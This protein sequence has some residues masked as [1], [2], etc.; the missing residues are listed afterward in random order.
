MKLA[1]AIRILLP[2]LRL[3]PWSIPT[4]VIVGIV[5]SF[6]EGIGI[7]LFIPF[8]QNLDPEAYQTSSDNP[9]LATLN[10][11]LSFV[12]RDRRIF[13]LPLLIFASII[14]KHSLAYVNLA[15][16]ARL[17]N[18]IGHHL[19]SRIFRQLMTIN[20][21]YLEAQDSGKLLNTLSGETWRV[22]D[23]IRL[24]VMLFI[25][26]ST[27]FVFTLLLLLLSWRLTL[28]VAVMMS[29]IA[30]SVQFLTRQS[31]SLGRQ[32]VV[33]NGELSTRMCEG[34]AGMRT[35]RAFGR[36]DYE[37]NRFDR[38][39][40]TTSQVFMKV[41]LL[42]GL[43]TPLYEMLSGALVL[44]IL[45]AVLIRDPSALPT[46]LT[47]LFILYRLQ[48]QIQLLDSNRIKL[49]TLT[50]SIADVMLFLDPTDKPYTQSGYATFNGLQK[51]IN[52]EQVSFRYTPEDQPA[53]QDIALII[54]QG[55]TTAL[56]GPSGAGKSTL[57]NL[58]CRFYEP[59]QGKITID[60]R[61]LPEL[62][63][64]MWRSRIAIVS[65][66]IYIFSGTVRDNIAYGRL[67]A[68]EAEIIA[69]AQQANAHDFILQLPEGYDT[70]VGDRGMRLSGGQRQR[71][72]LA[73]AIVR[74]PDILI[75]DEATNALD[76]ISEHLIQEALD[77]FSRAPRSGSLQGRTV[78]V[79]AHR[80]STIEQADQIAV[81]QQGRI[82]EV[83]SL[84]QLLDNN[85][86]FAQL[87]YLQYR[88]ANE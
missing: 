21:S 79:I 14:L 15:L 42:S 16:F 46:L 27:V 34:L 35:I 47:F 40:Q 7:S 33:A 6:A 88:Q 69:A 59:S 31:T 4:I 72:A 10:S 87:H 82:V 24:L 45:V 23:A 53:L 38:A 58:I 18:Q 43:V 86:L 61:P 49:K 29:L 55:K 62:N 56:V 78:I 81:L 20:Y 26:A 12:P 75:L 60:D 71:L 54:P 1:Q 37:Q 76:T 63:L 36:E 13:V 2:L 3:Y 25:S 66:D 17:T 57:I 51:G 28:L 48:P 41:D 44:C 80:L 39:S 84:K 70:P 73:R 5:A 19:R 74:D 83:G 11:F 9:L 77:Q 65:Q 67:E 32:A 8:L 68:S 52:F 50:G 22:T 85:G 64:E 30:L